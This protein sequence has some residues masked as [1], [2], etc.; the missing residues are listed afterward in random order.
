[1][2]LAID[3]TLFDLPDSILADTVEALFAAVYLDAGL[4]QARQV[5]VH[6][7]QTFFDQNFLDVVAKDSK[8]LLQEF[9]QKQGYALPLYEH[10]NTSLG[11]ET[12]FTVRVTIVDLALVVQSQ[13][14]SKRQAEKEAAAKLL[15]KLEEEGKVDYGSNESRRS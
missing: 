9:C 1:M 12:A 15:I 8:T 14:G 4:T 3:V 2:A 5:V 11:E 10:T 13:A 6:C 7:Y